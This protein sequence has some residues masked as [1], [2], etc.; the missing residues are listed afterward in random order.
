MNPISRGHFAEF[1]DLFILDTLV[2]RERKDPEK[3]LERKS[4]M[5]ALKRALY[6]AKARWSFIQVM[7]DPSDTPEIFRMTKAFHKAAPPEIVQ[8]MLKIMLADPILNHQWESRYWPEIPSLPVLRTFPEGSFGK[9]AA[10]FFDRWKLDP[11]LFPPP[12][13]S[14]AEDYLTSRMYQAHD[15]W[16]VLTG[17]TPDLV[18]ELGLQAFTS[19]QNKQAMSL[20]IIAGAIMHII[21]KNP[22]KS[23]SILRAISDGYEMGSNAKPLLTSH[24]FEDFAKPLSQLREELEIHLPRRV[25]SPQSQSSLQHALGAQ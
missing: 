25:A 2:F 4:I 16:H 13:F 21:Q 5:G 1:K 14:S 7:R 24:L 3:E 9:E 12:E 20:V 11:D 8:R 17:Y 6:S 10:N 15:F 22:E 19:G 23:E 18:D